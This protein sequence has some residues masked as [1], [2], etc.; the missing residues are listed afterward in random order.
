[1]CLRQGQIITT[2]R[3]SCIS[4]LVR[5]MFHMLRSQALHG[6]KLIIQCAAVCISAAALLILPQL[7][8]LLI[9]QYSMPPLYCLQSCL[10]CIACWSGR[11]AFVQCVVIATCVGCAVLAGERWLARPIGD[12]AFWLLLF[13]WCDV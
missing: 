12:A 11:F 13:A 8:L 5:M 9:G 3:Q 6:V 1:M 4:C 10:L 7:L 2:G